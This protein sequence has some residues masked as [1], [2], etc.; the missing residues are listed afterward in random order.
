[1][2]LTYLVN[3]YFI[4][5]LPFWNTILPSYTFGGRCNLLPTMT[6]GTLRCS[7]LNTKWLHEFKNYLLTCTFPK[8]VVWIITHI[9]FKRFII[10]HDGRSL[11]HLGEDMLCCCQPFEEVTIIFTKL[12]K[13]ANGDDFFTYITIK[14]VLDAQ[15]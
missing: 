11:V 3:N 6:L 9:T 1:M 10:Y 14:K 5:V 12:H 4:R 2:A 8:I 15:Y 7:I 13:G